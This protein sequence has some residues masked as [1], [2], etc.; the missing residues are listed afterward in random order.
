[1]RN[2]YVERNRVSLLQLS[3]PH[4][5]RRSKQKETDRERWKREKQN[6]GQMIEIDRYVERNRITLLQVSTLHRRRKRNKKGIDR[7]RDGEMQREKGR[8]R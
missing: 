7:E 3:T 6:K 4:R 8:D 5:S 1:M 2:R